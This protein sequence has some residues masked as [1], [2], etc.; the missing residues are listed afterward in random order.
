MSVTFPDNDNREN[1]MN[2]LA[3]DINSSI[4]TQSNDEAEINSK[5]T[6]LS[7]LAQEMVKKLEPGLEVSVDKISLY[8]TTWEV[9]EIVTPAL[10]FTAAYKALSKA[11]AARMLTTSAEEIGEEGGELAGEMVA[12]AAE[13]LAIPTS[14]KLIAGAGG[15]VLSV[16]IGFAVDAIDGAIAR[17]KLRHKIHELVPP[18]IIQKVN[19][20]QVSKLL[21]EVGSMLDAYQMMQKLG[22]TKK[23]MEEYID[24]TIEKFK[25]ELEQITLAVAQA[26]LAI[27]DTGRGSWTN[28]D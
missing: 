21:E 16:G 12:E 13:E 15:L 5:I 6:E 8:K 19:E 7:T 4:I 28:E 20:L 1:R 10:V 2:Q 9:A 22:Y 24:L 23:Q 18:R 27:L 11:V 14:A 25:A 17:K 3:S 26:Q